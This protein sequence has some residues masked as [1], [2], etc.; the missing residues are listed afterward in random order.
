MGSSPFAS[1]ILADLADF[2]GQEH[3][4]AIIAAIYSQPPRPSGRGQQITP[5]PV[6][7]AAAQLPNRPII[8]T[9]R[10]ID[11]QE[12]DFLQNLKPDLIIVAAYGLLLPASLLAIPTIMA[13]NV[14]TSLLPR[15]RG[16]TPIEAALLA[17]DDLSGITLIKMTPSLDAGPIIASK[18]TTITPT[19]NRQTLSEKLLTISC[20]LLRQ[21]LPALLAGDYTLTAQ[22]ESAASWSKKIEKSHYR[23]DPNTTTADQLARQI[24]ALYPKAYITL[25]ATPVSRRLLLLTAAAETN[26]HTDMQKGTIVKNSQ[27]DDGA[28]PLVM[29]LLMNL[30]INNDGNIFL[31]AAGGS[32]LRL[33]TVQP[34]NKKPMAA[35]DWWRGHRPKT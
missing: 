28:M 23:L 25:P 27:A 1:A 29:N 22:D 12:I 8:R 17:G 35:A 15:H 31:L 21:Q 11:Q 2:L 19:D 9:P 32:L 6:S 14:H 5:S 24:R 10:H 3:P 4:H 33:I 20:A 16:A 7:L 30:V 13:V 26:I 34:E 18:T